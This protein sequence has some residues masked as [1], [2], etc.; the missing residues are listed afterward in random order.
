MVSVKP[1]TLLAGAAVLAALFYAVRSNASGTGAAIGGAAVDMVSGVIG[2]AGVAVGGLVGVPQTSADKC[3]AAQAVGDTWEASFAC[4][5]SEFV[6][7]WW[8]K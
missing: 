3:A 7:W 5:A 8:R 1:L 4:P 2:G 6:S